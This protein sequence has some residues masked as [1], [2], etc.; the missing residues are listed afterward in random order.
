MHYHIYLFID[1]K[2]NVSF[3]KL[4]IYLG[5]SLLNLLHPFYRFCAMCWTTLSLLPTCF[6]ERSPHL[7]MQ[8]SVREEQW[9]KYK[10]AWEC[11]NKRNKPNNFWRC[12]CMHGNVLF[13]NEEVPKP[14]N[15]SHNEYYR[16]TKPF[17][18]IAQSY[19]MNNSF[20]LTSSYSQLQQQP[21]TT[22][23][24]VW[25]SVP[26]MIFVNFPTEGSVPYVMLCSGIL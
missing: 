6:A 1:I 9:Q 10:W 15:I 12:P 23:F 16:K 20:L 13:R 25:C 5:S 22:H 11:N 17:A 21:S 3:I 7:S 2:G 8:H 26:I 18:K 24:N 4:I 19:C 14:V